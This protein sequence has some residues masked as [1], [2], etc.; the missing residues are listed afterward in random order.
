MGI[1][2]PILKTGKLS[3]RG[4]GNLH[5]M[6]QLTSDVC[7]SPTSNVRYFFYKKVLPGKRGPSCL[8]QFFVLY[9]FTVTKGMCSAVAVSWCILPTWFGHASGDEEPCAPPPPIAVLEL[10]EYKEGLSCGLL[11]RRFTSRLLKN[12]S[13]S[14][15]GGCS[16]EWVWE[17]IGRLCF[18]SLG[19]CNKYW[20]PASILAQC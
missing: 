19:S 8:H 3:L 6:I 17:A 14:S 11:P 1:I 5:K 16:L 4:L 2:I 13:H 7:I 18:D 10:F 9:P 20:S 12:Q 15:P